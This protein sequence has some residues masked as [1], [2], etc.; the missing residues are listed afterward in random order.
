MTVGAVALAAAAGALAIV[1]TSDHA[2][3]S[4]VYLALTPLAGLSFAA[5]G[6][7]AWSRRPDNRTGPLLLG[8]AFAWF[9]GSLAAANASAVFAL[10]VALS[11]V[12]IAVFVH[13]VLAFPSGR[14]ATIRERGLVAASYV[15]AVLAPISQLLAEDRMPDCDGC[16]QSA[17]AVADS[18]STA[19]G[20]RIAFN[21][22]AVALALAVIAIL[23]R[24][25]RSAGVARRRV[26][27]PVFLAG[28]VTLVLVAV[29]FATQDVSQTVT[30][31]VSS[32][33]LASFCSVPFVFVAGLLR[34]R[35][36]RAGA[37]R[38]LQEVPD[39]PTLAEAQAGLRRALGDPTARLAFWADG[40]GYVD[41]EGK[42]FELP[43]E[44][45]TSATTKIEYEGDPLAA[46]VHDPSLREEQP[47]LLADVVAAARVALE[48]D[49]S[50]RA[51]RA[52][53][54]R[55][56]A[57]LDA[58]PDHM[59]RIRR[60]GTYVDFHSHSPD[61]LHAPPDEIVGRTVRDVMPE[62]TADRLMSAIE[63]ALANGAIET[64]EYELPLRGE[65]RF[66]E[67]RIVRSGEDEVLA[68]VRDIT[69]RKRT[70]QQLRASRARLVEAGDAE[71]RRLE[72]NLH[73]GA[74]QRLVSISLALRLAQA[75]LSSDVSGASEILSSASVELALAL[76]ELRELARG[77]H[78][79][80]L[81][82]RGLDAALESLADRAPLPVEIEATPAE[83]LPAPVE[84]AAFYVVSESLANVAKYAR[85]TSVRVSVTRF[86]GRAVVEIADDGVGGADPAL[87]SGLRGLADRVEA[88]NGRLRVESPPG[89]GT[90]VRA[91]IPC[92]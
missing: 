56:R 7:I 8:V 36:A 1:A 15:V 48:K 54:L 60:D 58:M 22:V 6:L 64:V 2:D 51:L 75:K 11:S 26:L 85:A 17:I 42:P 27:G 28:L 53:E 87:G 76:E 52:S 44:T 68:I 10:G 31:A 20:L 34:T 4:A 79:A 69:E 78:P 92:A 62:A 46:L 82:E 86:N 38:L 88:L 33:A 91:E 77:I 63:A 5:A 39:S 72:R 83:R 66:R 84:A 29:L 32:L 59:F 50:L 61:E 25:W 35:L 71:R 3:Q 81:T 40:L 43:P 80:V 67:A 90:S 16:P 30:A 45:A 65:R 24:R 89:A 14:L 73:D 55:T 74:Q 13:L 9:A 57:L 18:S 12:F 70:E 21:A 19:T 23:V 41:T 47:E 37:G 49:R